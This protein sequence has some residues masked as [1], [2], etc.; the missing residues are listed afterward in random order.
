V[1]NAV[2]AINPEAIIYGEGWTMGSTIDGSPM[3]NQTQISKIEPLEGAIGGIAVFNDA[4]RDGLKGSV[5]NA[6]SKGYISGNGA[7][8]FPSVLFGIKGGAGTGPSWTV[9]NAMV[10]NYMSAHD[11]NTLWDKLALSNGDDTVEARL[12]MNRLGATLLM[13]SKGTVFFQAGEEMLRTKDGDENSYKSSDAI[14]NIDWSVLAE[15]NAE[16]DM[17]LY[18]KELIRVR[19]TYDIFRTINSA[20]SAKQLDNGQAVITLDNHVGGKA[21]VISNPTGEAMTYTLTGNWNM[22]INGVS[23]IEGAPLPCQ[24]EITIPAYSAVVLVNDNCIN[25]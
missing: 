13:I 22:V 11:N 1:E 17:M 8:S 5:F 14:N 12:A 3:A 25:Q 23:V 20:V 4:I 21:L 7:G 16:Y 19:K 2:H 15:G 18:Y 10:V 9:Q 6:T 24:G